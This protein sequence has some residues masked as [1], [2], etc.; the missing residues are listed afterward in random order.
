VHGWPPTWGWSRS[1]QD[2]GVLDALA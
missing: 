2:E 1:G